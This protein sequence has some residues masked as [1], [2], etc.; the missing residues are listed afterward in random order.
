MWIRKLIRI[1]KNG[2]ILR[3]TYCKSQNESKSRIGHIPPTTSFSQLLDTRDN[4]G[5]FLWC[6]RKYFLLL[7][8]YMSV[9]F[10]QGR[11]SYIN[12]SDPPYFKIFHSFR[13][14]HLENPGERAQQL[15]D[16]KRHSNCQIISINKLKI[17]TNIKNF[18]LLNLCIEPNQWS[19]CLALFLPNTRGRGGGYF[20]YA[21][22]NTYLYGV[23]YIPG[24]SQ[25]CVLHWLYYPRHN[26]K[27]LYK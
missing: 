9:V 8:L 23:F 14:C 5:L 3:R 26:L 10:G 6:T 19:L 11:K 25:H 12:Y 13:C 18:Q 22:Y 15:R 21:L 2:H 16:F 4:L 27:K 7:L 24:T 20:L 1:H 17:L